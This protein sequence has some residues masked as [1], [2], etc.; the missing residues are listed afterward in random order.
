[1]RTLTIISI[2]LSIS[3]TSYSQPNAGSIGN[4]QN[5]CYGYAPARLSFVETPSGGVTPY[6]Y[7]WQRSNDGSTWND[8]TGT[9]ASQPAYSPPVLAR[10]TYF[11]CRVTDA[12]S[13]QAITNTVTITVT[14]SLDPGAIQGDQTVYS[15]V[16]PSALQESRPASGGSGSYSYQWQ[17]SLNGLSWSDI[18]DARS[19]LYAPTALISDRW[20]RRIASDGLCGITASNAVK[21]T[22]SQITLFTTETPHIINSEPVHYNMGTEFQVRTDGFI[23]K[24]RLFTDELEAGDHIIRLWLDNGSGFS[25]LAGPY[26]W[27]FQEGIEGWREFELPSPVWVEG[28]ESFRYMISITNVAGNYYYSQSENYFIPAVTNNYI[29]YTIGRHITP[30]DLIPYFDYYESMYFRDLVFIPFSP[31][32]AGTSQTICYGT[33]PASLI[34]A[35]PPAGGT[36]EYAFQ[37]QSS[38]DNSNWSNIPGATDPDY[39]PQ[40]LTG[41]TYLRRVVSSDNMTVACTPVLISVYPLVENARL[42]DSITI[43]DNTSTNFNI[44]IS[45]GSPPYTINYARNGITQPSVRDYTNG[46]DISTGILTTGSYTYS[47]ISVTD[48]HGCQVMDL[49]SSITVT[50]SGAY[51]PPSVTGKVLVLINGSSPNYQDYASYIKPY[52]LNF[53]IPFDEYDNPNSSGHPDFNNYA[54]II[55]GHSNVYS[56]YSYPVTDLLNTLDA[57]TGLCS[58]DPVLFQNTTGTLSSDI[59]DLSLSDNQISIINTSHFITE[60]HQSDQFNLPLPNG[61]TPFSNNYETI[62]LRSQMPVSQNTALTGGTDLA[63]LT[64]GVTTAAILETSEYGSGRIVNWNNY[65]WMY[66]DYLGPL[67]GMDDLLWRSIVWAARKP[68]V[69]QGLPPMITMRVDD[70]DGYGS[71]VIDNFKWIDISNEF[72]LIP[73]CGTFN[74]NIPAPYVSTLKSLIDNN[75][76]TAS[77]HAFDYETFIYYNHYGEAG[78]SAAENVIRSH[79]YYVTNQLTMSKYVASHYYELDLDALEEMHNMGIEFIATHMQ[80]SSPYHDWW[81]EAGPYRLNRN[82]FERSSSLVPVYYADY[83]SG[84][85]NQFFN[86]VTEIRDDDG[87]EWVP[88]NDDITNSVAQGVRQLTRALTSMALPTL[89][90][91]QQNLG[92]TETNWRTILSSIHSAISRFNPQYKSMDYAVQYI[93]AQK[94]L[95]IINV[96]DDAN[97]VHITYTGQP[98]M[99]TKCYLFTESGTQITHKLVTLPS[100][101]SGTLTVSTSK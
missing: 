23:H 86:C 72:G 41:N 33:A 52:L 44:L 46:D 81:L 27:I 59:A 10:T 69:L 87:Y 4:D 35:E 36:G 31:G 61:T 34:E 37:W 19:L 7:R 6:S 75:K 65:S 82:T 50:V 85:G 8:I 78:F 17:S 47:L 48:S 96:T 55:F 28:N 60:Y 2:L 14:T 84:G 70:V 98:D 54:L 100:I 89:F 32:S 21:I 18:P 40:V 56:S 94:N 22:V 67:Y 39:S 71:D 42:R 43:F 73:W 3:F 24:V 9:S 45:G 15:G 16:T 83:V 97:L 91:H 5:I 76:A 20:F 38:P 93:R 58:F 90:T 88:R 66:E 26:N 49:G 74:D 53:G 30:A 99:K 63:T 68:F 101:S 57:G 95:S 77:P 29:K 62:T 13:N 92:I 51:N 80:F 11:R 12:S 25:L 79:D 64:N 1:M